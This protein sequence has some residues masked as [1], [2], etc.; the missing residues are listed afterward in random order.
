M[1]WFDMPNK[2]LFFRHAHLKIE[3]F[4]IHQVRC[5]KKRGDLGIVGPLLGVL[6]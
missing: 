6:G 3:Y 4:Q 2:L 1:I 5:M